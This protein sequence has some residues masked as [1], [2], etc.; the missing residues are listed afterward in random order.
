M[1][2]K[3]QFLISAL[4]LTVR[5]SSLCGNGRL[6]PGEECDASI[7]TTYSQD[8]CT[9][10]CKKIPD[11]TLCETGMGVCRAGQCQSRQSQCSTYTGIVLQI[12]GQAVN[13]PYIPCTNS[14]SVL[15]QILPPVLMA[16]SQCQP[17]CQGM[18][19][20]NSAASTCV[21]FKA[22]TNLPSASADNLGCIVDNT[23]S[24]TDKTQIMNQVQAGV[25]SAGTCRTDSCRATRCSNRGS[26]SLSPFA[27]YLISQYAGQNSQSN[28][29]SDL[30]LVSCTCDS[31]YFGRQCQFKG[32][33][34]TI[35]VDCVPP[36]SNF[37]A[38]SVVSQGIFTAA[39]L[40]AVFGTLLLCL[41][42]F[43]LCCL[44]C[45]RRRR[46]KDDEMYAARKVDEKPHPRGNIVFIPTPGNSLED[47]TPPRTPDS[48]RAESLNEHQGVTAGKASSIRSSG[49]HS[50]SN[51]ADRLQ[52]HTSPPDQMSTGSG[53]ILSG[54]PLP[55]ITRKSSPPL[56]HSANDN[57]PAAAYLRATHLYQ[58][59]LVDEIDMQPNDLLL[60]IKAY[61][62]GWG[63]ALNLRSSKEGIFP[64]SFTKRIQ[65]PVGGFGTKTTL[66]DEDA[67][68]N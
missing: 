31:G 32:D 45:N 9:L 39:I 12:P 30:S 66:S 55:L 58:S 29:S 35:C 46:V 57:K 13:G 50:M 43:G 56:G 68:L 17:A 51:S 4:M 6:D 19:V 26:C 54:L 64:M 47:N 44:L 49:D 27:Q 8:C 60:L 63:R 10:D 1:S 25:C 11:A 20:N 28:A 5:A 41:I 59:R 34:N 3:S 61:D 42:V 48:V 21:D 33:S 16:Q 23:N 22:Y 18:N 24:Q 40:G 53:E 62:D 14:Q 15:T 7:S 37:T 2:W 36:Q 67:Q 38:D 52:R 65:T